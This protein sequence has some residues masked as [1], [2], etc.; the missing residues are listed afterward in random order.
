VRT[1]LASG[2]VI[3]ESPKSDPAALAETIRVKMETA[4]GLKTDLI[5]RPIS[6]IRKMVKSNPFKDF[7]VTSETKFYV[8]FL[9][10]RSRSASAYKYESPEK[11]VRIFGL[12]RGDVGAVLALSPSRGTTA[13]LSILDKQFGRNVTTRNWTTIQK[14]AESRAEKKAG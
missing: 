8:T 2:N 12:S 1:V 11:D 9:P 10:E 5:L 3:F 4:L 13:L 7:N 6:E 14:I